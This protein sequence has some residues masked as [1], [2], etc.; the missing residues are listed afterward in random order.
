MQ[1]IT[2]HYTR[3][4]ELSIQVGLDGFSFVV[5][6]IA[7]AGM[8][9][10]AILRSVTYRDSD[11]ATILT[12]EPMLTAVNPPIDRVF[13]G[14]S[15]DQVLLIPQPLFEPERAEQYL[16]AANLY[17]PGMTTLT[18]NLLSGQAAAVWQADPNMVA[19]LLQLYPG[20]LF[21]HPLLL[22]LEA[23]PPNHIHAILDGNLVHLTICHDRLY[24]A[25]TIPVDTP[26]ELLYYIQK[27]IKHDGFTNYRLILT[28]EGAERLRSF[29]I[30]YFDQVDAREITYYNQQRVREICAS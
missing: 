23:T 15:T 9:S 18:N 22:E 28:G 17:T 27:L 16:T 30:R 24:A 19:G 5:F 12:R 6:D 7:P 4:R 20:A 14:Y 2:E 3:S 8:G 29:F 26:E 13:I 11:M 10:E 25:E 1:E 21:Y